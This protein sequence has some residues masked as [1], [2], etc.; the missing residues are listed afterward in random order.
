MI[1]QPLVECWLDGIGSEPTLGVLR[2]VLELR[3]L[4]PDSDGSVVGNDGRSVHHEHRYSSEE[5]P[6]A[7]YLPGLLLV[8][9]HTP[10]VRRRYCR[11]S[12]PCLDQG[13][14]TSTDSS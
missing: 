2:H 10:H 9:C 1:L 8:G 4:R 14:F 13:P 11:S 3:R 12:F 7:A 5:D 6:T